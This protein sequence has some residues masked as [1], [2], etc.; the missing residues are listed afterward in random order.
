[1]VFWDDVLFRIWNEKICNRIIE[2]FQTKRVQENLLERIAL[3][4]STEYLD[5]EKHLNR[6]AI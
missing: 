2:S 6:Q 1:M 3:I 5:S 4:N